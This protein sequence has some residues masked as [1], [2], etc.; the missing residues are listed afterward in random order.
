[1]QP[2]QISK[3]LSVLIDHEVLFV[4][5]GGVAA[6]MHGAPYTTFD[7]DIVHDVTVG[8]VDRL[9]A[10]LTELDAKYRDPAGRVIRVSTESLLGPGH[11]LL[12]TK[13][14]PLDILGTI[15]GDRTYSA[16]QDDVVTVKIAE[17]Q[18]LVIGLEQLI[19]T[20]RELRRAKDF[21]AIE[22]LQV[23]LNKR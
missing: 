22:M 19:A 7:L 16:L 5:V 9:I 13:Y 12:I 6:I 17:Q 21:A 15:V 1:M 2:V 3:L 8:N 23:I 20:K 18:V 11:H 10:A 14:G 4:V